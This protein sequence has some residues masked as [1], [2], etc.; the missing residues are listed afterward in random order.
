MT[1]IAADARRIIA[2][3]LGLDEDEVTPESSFAD[4]GAD[5]LDLVELAMS[6]EEAF[7]LDLP[8]DVLEQHPTVGA[9]TGWLEAAHAR[10]Q[11]R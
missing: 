8:E 3:H 1:D 7:G 9:A 10:R 6:L 5:E 11:G 2:G 4:L